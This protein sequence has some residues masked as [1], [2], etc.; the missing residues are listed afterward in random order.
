MTQFW[1]NDPSILLNKYNL[2][3]WPTESMTMN[4]KLNAITRLVILLCISGF[5][6]T[7]N[8][9]FVWISILTLVCIVAYY[10]LN[11]QPKE[12]FEKQDFSKH[13]LPTDKNPLMNVLLPEINGNP[14]R[15]S[16]LKSYLPDNEKIIN[17]KVK[18][19]FS[20]H[21]DPRIFQG[22]DNELDLE[23]SMR[24]FYT[25]ASTTI[26][27]DQEG[28][29]QFLYGDMISSKEGDPVALGRQNPRL[30]SIPN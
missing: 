17:N 3:F 24:N 15:K 19:H 8:I 11:S 22:L 27:N 26:P 14:N 4:N 2:V 10:K 23:Y 20:K 7:Q 13:T 30:G 9:N 25:T 21:L 29:S 1:I 18:N 28:F 5:V 6:A 16:A 12:N